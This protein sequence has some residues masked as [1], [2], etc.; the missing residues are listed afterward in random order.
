M[1]VGW[2]VTV[3]PVQVD[4]SEGRSTPCISTVCPAA[5]FMVLPTTVYVCGGTAEVE[6]AVRL[7][8]GT[9]VAGVMP[10]PELDF[11]LAAWT[12]EAVVASGETAGAFE[13]MLSL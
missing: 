8:A 13:V 5:F 3:V 6:V 7:G 9:D 2:P 12:P 10:G 11:A 4:S 1:P